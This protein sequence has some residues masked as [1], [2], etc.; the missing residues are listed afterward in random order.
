MQE[1]EPAAILMYPGSLG[2][3]TGCM[4]LSN[5]VLA[6]ESLSDDVV[7]LITKVLWEHYKELVPIHGSFKSWNNTNF[8]RLEGVSLP[9]HQG[10]IRFY[11]EKGV[12]TPEMDKV[13]RRL[14][15]K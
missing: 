13:Q 3:K 6:R 11:K 10:A 12:W 15:G 1:I 14:L 9:Y 5:L 4:G 2:G 7:Y 8:M